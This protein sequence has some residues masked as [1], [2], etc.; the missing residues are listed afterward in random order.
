M[1]MTL[2][3]NS[4][5]DNDFWT[6]L[7][8]YVNEDVDISADEINNSEHFLA[9]F[10]KKAED[11]RKLL[12]QQFFP[13]N[14][15]SVINQLKTT[16][17]QANILLKQHGQLQTE[18][19]KL[20]I[21]IK[22]HEDLTETLA[23]DFRINMKRLNEMKKT[24]YYMKCLEQ[25]QRQ[26]ENLKRLLEKNQMYE[27]IG[28][29]ENLINLTETIKD[30]SSE[31][32]RNYS[33]NLTAYWYEQLKVKLSVRMEELLKSI[34]YPYINRTSASILNDLFTS[35]Y[36]EF[37]QCFHLILR[38]RLPTNSKHTDTK[39]KLRFPGWK[40]LPLFILFL[41]Q[42]LK[43]RFLF[44]FYGDKKTN[45]MAKKWY[46]LEQDTAKV[47]L[48]EIFQSSTAF[49]S[50]YDKILEK[51]N[52]DLKIPECAETFLTLL[53]AMEGIYLK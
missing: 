17:K 2:K 28:V 25:F 32:L 49:T 11:D 10:L 6:Q 4:K 13:G 1:R 14:P 31:H 29:Y 53:H 48:R 51:T 15:V 33:E 43:K 38:I 3:S 21:E 24:V 30:T 19:R 46:Q 47:R 42:P 52:D 37:K 39:S 34:Q 9:K 35:Y 27:C 5:N 26:S 22:T 8:S 20:S 44:H 36:E 7:I 12:D 23:Q 41:I 45:N 16:V 18:E 40:P 50:V